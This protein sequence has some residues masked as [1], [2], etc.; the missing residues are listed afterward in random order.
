MADNLTL[1]VAGL[2]HS[3]TL[4]LDKYSTVGALK[5]QVERETHLPAGYQRLVARGKKL[6]DDSV[7]FESI[8][9]EHRTR[10]MLLHNEFYAA[11]QAG[12]TAINAL[13]KEI[14]ELVAK[15]DDSTSP[16]VIHELV[17]QICCKLDAIDTNGSDILRTMRKQAIAKAE[18]LDISLSSTDEQK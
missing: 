10:L 11:D 18:A 15:A 3:L 14:D 6:D 5:E 2:G 16:A 1:R 4:D 13:T 17:T 12:V 7:T 9:I 8:G